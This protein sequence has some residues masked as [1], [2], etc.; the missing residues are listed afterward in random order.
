MAVVTTD[1]SGN[2]V[3]HVVALA[4]SSSP[5]T[6]PSGATTAM[7]AVMIVTNGVPVALVEEQ[8]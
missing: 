4:K 3:T 7:A 6:M 2:P 5:T 8:E 1:T